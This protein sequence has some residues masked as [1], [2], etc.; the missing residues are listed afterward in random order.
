MKVLIREY[1]DFFGPY[2]LVEKIFFWTKKN[3][4]FPDWVDNLA[5]RFADSCLGEWYTRHAQKNV[6][7]CEEKRVKVTIDDYD[8]WSMDHTLSY[9]ILPML[10][11]LKENK[12]G[13]PFVEFEDRPSHLI[14]IKK[15]DQP[16]DV[17]EFHFEA[18]DWV[19][20]EM[21]FAF[22]SKVG[23]NKDWEDQFY[24]DV[25]DRDGY[26]VYHSRIDNGFK[27]FGKYYNSLWN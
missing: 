12:H 16:Y 18:W 6:D 19:M 4:E 7:R 1:C 22:D 14:P 25:F 27:L 21:I 2:Q 23:E 13:A 11:Q 24:L 9:I 20:D 5:E 3:G 15:P 10:K 17:D 8:T 26:K